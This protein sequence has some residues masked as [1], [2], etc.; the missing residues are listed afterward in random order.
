MV[1]CIDKVSTKK[2]SICL[3]GDYNLNYLNKKEKEKLNTIILPYDLHL[4]ISRTA[5]RHKNGSCSL[6]EYIIT[7]NGLRGKYYYVF[8]SPIESDHLAQVLFTDFTLTQKQKP[9]RK[10][11]FDKR[12]YDALNFRNSLNYI[13]WSLIY[14]SNDIEEMFS[15]FESLIAIVIRLHAPIR[16]IFI[17]N[18]IFHW[19][20]SLSQTQQK[21][22]I[23]R[24]KNFYY[25]KILIIS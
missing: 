21:A 14:E 5:T 8:D 22:S 23:K 11:T 20:I 16:K 13:N 25:Q 2:K 17:R 7:E 18:L 19:Q 1:L 4:M 12:N 3:I 24:D 10:W 9:L 6:L 15:R